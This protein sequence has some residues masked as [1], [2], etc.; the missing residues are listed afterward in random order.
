MIYLLTFLLGIAISYIGS[1][2]VGA[3]NMAV[4]QATLNKGKKSGMFIG[5]GAILV[6]MTYCAIPLFGVKALAKGT[7]AFDWMIIGSIPVLITLGLISI[8]RRKKSAKVNRK[9]LAEGSK[10]LKEMIYGAT[11]CGTNPMIILFW[12]QVVFVLGFKGFLNNTVEELT[13]MLSVPTGT[14]LLYLTFIFISNRTK[15]F[16]SLRSKIRVNLAVGII[17]IGL[18]VYLGVSYFMGHKGNL[19]PG[20]VQVDQ[21]KDGNSPPITLPFLNGS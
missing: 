12:T 5:L 10:P 18:G 7:A 2:P 15:R 17:F 21:R 8:I 6:E 16:I 1:I 14:F 19:K 13:F 9:Q 3:V 20:K 11:L 4:V